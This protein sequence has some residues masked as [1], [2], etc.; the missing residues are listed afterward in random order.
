M[1]EEKILKISEKLSYVPRTV[2]RYRN[3]YISSEAVK[4]YSEARILKFVKNKT[5][6]T[7]K[8]TKAM[9]IDGYIIEVA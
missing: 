4:R 1:R 6:K 9:T 3:C 7:C 2:E 8:I 5:G